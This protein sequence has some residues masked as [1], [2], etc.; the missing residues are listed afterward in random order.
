MFLMGLRMTLLDSLSLGL[1]SVVGT[2]PSV[3]F[4]EVG[5]YPA[6]QEFHP[7]LLGESSLH[8]K[9]KIW[10]SQVHLRFFSVK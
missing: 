8:M 7:L 5:G 3:W 10:G 4:L 1:M 9:Q 2:E 6:Y